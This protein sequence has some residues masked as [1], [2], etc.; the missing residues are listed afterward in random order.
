MQLIRYQSARGPAYGLVQAGM[1]Y[2]LRQPDIYGELAPGAA[3][4]P[5]ADLPLLPPVQPGKIVA[6]GRNYADHAQ[7]QH[8]PLPAEPLLF[9]KA[10]SSVIGPGAAIQL[11]P[12]SH[13]VE[14]EAELAV[15]IGK[16]CKHVNLAEA[17]QVILGVTCANDVTA[18]DVQRA[19]GQW[20]RGKSF[21]T[22]C[23]LGPHI[24]TQLAPPEWEQLSLV[25][26]V[27]GAVRQR[28][29]TADM[30]FKIP[31]LIAYIT[32]GMTL[33]PGDVILTG[34]PAGVGPLHAGDVVEVEI[35][36]VGRLHNTVI[37]AA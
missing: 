35:E 9:L 37:G 32:A 36:R 8:A 4:G 12:L 30:L 34:T 1:A 23:P 5:L 10:P 17:A 29:H 27:N 2:A 19:D 11:T 15:V 25:C 22:F 18:R 7:E 14:Y 26:R 33:E 20:A 21:D 13:Q 16:R 24:I 6:V 31:H 3:L 28:G